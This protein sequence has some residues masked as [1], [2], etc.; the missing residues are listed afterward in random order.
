MGELEGKTIGIFAEDLYEEL[1]LWY[2]YYRLKEAGAKIVLIG[3][4]LKEI[5][6]GKHG[7]LPVKVDTDA[8][9]VSSEDFDGIVVPGG[10]APDRLRRYPAVLK[11]VREVYEQGKPVAA[12]CHGAW[13][14]ISANIMKGHKA[15]SFFA[16]RDDIENAGATYFDQEVVRD[17]NI[18]TSR[19]PD[20]LPAFC[21]E[22]IK[23]LSS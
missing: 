4:G 1:E 11:L 9:K 12:I 8:N 21:R 20:D 10:Y 23:A 17:R 5:Y 13:V 6:T 14:L 16:I 3:T 22:I 15:T 2:P 19:T 18:I 7:G